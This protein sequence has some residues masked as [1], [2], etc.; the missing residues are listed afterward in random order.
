MGGAKVAHLVLV[1]W[2]VCGSAGA[3]VMPMSPEPGQAPE[4]AAKELYELKVV[5]SG[6][7]VTIRETERGPTHSQIEFEMAV[8]PPTFIASAVV[9]FKAVYDVAKERGFEYAFISGPTANAS[10]PQN[11]G[12]RRGAM[13]VFLTKDRE[14]PLRALLG[15]DYSPVAQRQF[16]RAGWLSVT[17]FA[18]MF[19]EGENRGRGVMDPLSD[20]IGIYSHS[21]GGE[22]AYR[23]SKNGQDYFIETRAAAAWR[24]P[25]RL[26]VPTESQRAEAAA[27]GIRF[28]AG[29]GTADEPFSF[30]RIEEAVPGSGG[31][32]AIFYVLFS[33]FGPDLLY[34]LP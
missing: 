33:G 13:K 17:Q 8:L 2:V 34:K 31:R 16:D 25:V 32:T 27:Q 19:G 9:L 10:P 4:R 28:S 29:L 21:S 5:E 15:A 18:R 11:D 7:D 26:V 30:L 14:T 24:T 6:Y 23:V 20:L 1:A 3:A 12:R 22:P